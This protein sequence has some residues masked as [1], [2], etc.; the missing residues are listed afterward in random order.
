V[1]LARAQSAVDE[2]RSLRDVQGELTG[3]EDRLADNL[4]RIDGIRDLPD[5]IQVADLTAPGLAAPAASQVALGPQVY[6]LDAAAGKVVAL[7]REGEPKPLTLFEEGRPAGPDRTGKARHITWWAPEG[8]RPGLLLVLDDQR[9]L[10]S[11]DARGDVRPVALGDTAEWKTDTGIVV[12]TSH[13]YVLDAGANQVWRYALNAGGFPGAPEPLLTARA[14]LKDVT[15]ISIAAGAPMIATSDGRLLRVA[16]GL[17]Q[18]M[19]PVATDRPLLA[20]APPQLNGGDGLLYVADR[21]NQRVVLLGTDATFRGQ[22][23]H[24]RLAGLQSIALDEAAGV[25]YAIAGQSLVR[26][27]IPK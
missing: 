16:D 18:P 15:G 8:N 24:H 2:A 23:V 3:L 27:T 21:G 19:Q 7:P 17:A 11:V 22:L 20:P 6:L 5:L 1:L 12:G 26:A 25:L 14:S 4:A 9:R 10:Y 13:L